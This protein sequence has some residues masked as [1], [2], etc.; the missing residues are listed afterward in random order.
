MIDETGHADNE[1]RVFLD[2]FM[3]IMI[4]AKHIWREEEAPEK[5]KCDESQ[6]T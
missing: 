5:Q 6:R 2:D 3:T 4:K 1:G